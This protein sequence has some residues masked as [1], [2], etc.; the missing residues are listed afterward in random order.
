MKNITF[1]TCFLFF[2]TFSL[3]TSAQVTQI[4]RGSIFDKQSES[5]L[6]G[7]AVQI[8]GSNPILGAVADENGN[9]EI[10][11]VPTGRHLLTV[12]FLGYNTA[13]IPNVLI[14]AGKETVLNISLEE[15]VTKLD[16]VVVS[17]KTQKGAA[18]NEL[19]TISAGVL[20]RRLI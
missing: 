12:S 13:N 18:A 11:N 8:A 9:F 6:V 5:P 4:L 16:A 19:A 17:A 2:L 20:L 10:K 1:L 15:S 14:N 7:A 3:K